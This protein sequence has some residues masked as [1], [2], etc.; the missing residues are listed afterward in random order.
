M[1]YMCVSL[2]ETLFTA[3]SFIKKN[4]Q[5]CVLIKNEEEKVIGVLSQGDIAAALLNGVDPYTHVET[6]AAPNFLYLNER[7]MEKAY[8]IFK[9][10]NLTLLPVLDKDYHL[11]DT[12]TLQDIYQYLEKERKAQ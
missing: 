8:T 1:D 12:I 3:M 7:D 5:R 4:K 11:T 10:K 6:I 2:K 9:K